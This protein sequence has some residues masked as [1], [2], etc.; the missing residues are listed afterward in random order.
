V[1]TA[2]AIVLSALAATVVAVAACSSTPVLTTGSTFSAP[3]S[4]AL[5]W[6]PDRDLLFIANASGDDL[7]AMSLC[8]QVPDGKGGFVSGS[9][10]LPVANTCLER[11][12]Q[13][14][15]PGPI[16]VFPGS[17]TAG[18]RPTR[19][20][21]A[22]LLK[23]SPDG[24]SSYFGAVLVAGLATSGT[25]GDPL[26][27]LIDANNI[28]AASQR[29]PPTPVHPPF[30]VTLPGPAVDVV[31]SEVPGQHVRAFVVS[32]TPAGAAILTAFEVSS[33]D[34]G[35]VMVPA[36]RC[37]LDL[38]ATRLALV[39]GT[40][41]LLPNDGGPAHVYVADGT[42]DGTPGGKGDGAVEV[43]VADMPPYDPATFTACPNVRRL[44]ASDPGDPIRV[45]R[46]LRSLALNPS[47]FQIKSR[48]SDPAPVPAVP[49]RGGS[50]LLG[51][52]LG[53]SA[54]CGVPGNATCGEGSIVIVQTNPGGTSRVAPAPP[55]DF[56]A[57]PAGAPAMA[58]LHALSGAREITF[59]R[60]IPGCPNGANGCV[61]ITAGLSTR[62]TALQIQL[63]AAA[64]TDDGGTVLVNVIDR[65]FVDD[66]RDE[67]IG[68][69]PDPNAA[70]PPALSGVTF[71][72][73]PPIGAEAPQLA[74]PNV[75]PPPV[76][77][78]FTS[79][80]LPHPCPDVGTP[81]CLN[82]GVTTP[83][84]WIVVWHGVMPGLE[85]VAG[86]LH[87]DTATGPVR[88]ELTARDLTP[89]I[90]SPRL[91]LQAGDVVHVH[92]VANP[93]GLCPDLAALPTTQDLLIEAVEPR[94]LVINPAGRPA[95]SVVPPFAFSTS[96][97]AV[98]VAVDIRT[99]STVGGEWL[100]EAGTDV[101]GRVNHGAL[102]VSKAQRF[103]NP[104]DVPAPRPQMDIEVAF[105]PIGAVPILSGQQFTFT[106]ARGTQPTTI[107][108][109][110]VLPQGPVGDVFAYQSRHFSSGSI[111]A[112]N[113]LFT[114]LT[115][116]NAV[117]RSSPANLGS[118]AALVV[119]R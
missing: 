97:G 49:A 70:L 95:P 78:L 3:T 69:A 42:P 21:G 39:P 10:G 99:G 9:T 67:L 18:S 57:A 118:E 119:Y 33:Q 104:I 113:I 27:R 35:P 117:V 53:S 76:G 103:D 11:E 45:A 7:T 23:V 25:G 16:R 5:T 31:A 44:P 46:P 79:T 94:A 58:P 89:W 101:R 20:A 66:L 115:G 96:C 29:T 112:P 50:I 83:L 19:L 55:L 36:A 60:P 8:T 24:T 15:L 72:P 28:L 68:T 82:K 63:G 30:D 92:S 116:N 71:F 22:R 84:R 80:G 100:V 81:G 77:D 93:A 1:R 86:I 48:D 105:A 4:I 34:S 38:V 41:D 114:A 85:S 26:I 54:L 52:T 51:V 37:T 17:I 106:T 56:F 43:P 6:G 74:F 111:I 91:A 62:L 87:R 61:D 12:D 102:F 73:S 59:L 32:Q 98:S 65:R 2:L 40:D 88:L 47:F 110:N 64:S 107:R 75:I 90:T 13:E 14:L 109:T 108:E